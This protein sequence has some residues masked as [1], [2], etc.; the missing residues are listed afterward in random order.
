MLQNY[1]SELKMVVTTL[2][3]SRT[4]SQYFWNENHAFYMIQL[5]KNCWGN[6]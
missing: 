6:R 1:I 2:T 4:E 3:T 5:A